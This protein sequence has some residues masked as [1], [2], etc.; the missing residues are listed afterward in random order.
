MNIKK[1]RISILIVWT[2]IFLLMCFIFG[3]SLKTVDESS[4]ESSGIMA[5]I[6]P[7][8]DPMNRI[9]DEVFHHYVRKAAHMTEFA[10]LGFLLATASDLFR[11]MYKRKFIS[12]SFLF[13]ILTAV[14]DEFLQSFSD[15]SAEVKDVLI[16]FSGSILGIA[17]ASLIILILIRKRRI[18][19]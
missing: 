2:L 10:V 17:F 3:N 6:K 4:A 8:I 16:D 12:F 14:T 19:E 7:I 15:R 18:P 1:F 13:C 5:F 11:R 9:D